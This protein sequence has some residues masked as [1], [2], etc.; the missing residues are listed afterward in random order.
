MAINWARLVQG[1]LGQFTTPV[2]PPN[3]KL[4][5]LPQAVTQFIQASSDPDMDLGVLGKIIETD[6]G[7]TLELLKHVNSAHIGL[8]TR[9][10]T[11]RQALS[12][13]GL[14]PTRN[15]LI[16][17]GTRAAIQSRQSRLINQNCFWIAA[18]QK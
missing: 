13:L 3:M 1:A 12:L 9:A 8:R 6:S 17:V 4:P 15:L 5:A 14:K 18:L 2:L 10:S 11:A 7:L 16:T